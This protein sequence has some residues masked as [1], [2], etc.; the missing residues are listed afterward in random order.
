MKYIYSLFFLVPFFSFNAFGQSVELNTSQIN[1]GTLTYG[2][3]DSVLVEITNLLNEEVFLE[4]PEFFDFYGSSPFYV[5]TYPESIEANGAGSFYVVFNPIHNMV[6]NSEMVVKTSGNR[7]AVALDLIGECVYPG[8]YY[9]TTYNL[10]DEDLESALHTLLAQNYQDYGYSGARDRI[11]MEIDNQKVNGQGA[12]QN[13]LTR[14]YIGTDAVGYTSRSNAQQEYN[15]NT[16][17]TFP[18]GYFNSNFPMKS[19]MH[20]LFVSDINA[21]SVRG[22]LRFGNVVSGI[23]WSEGGSKRGLQAD[24]QTVFEP[25]DEQKGPSA[26][27]ILYFV[28]RY[29]N[30]DGFLNVT[31][32]ATLRD[33]SATFPPD[34]I[35]KT[36]NEDIFAYQHNRNPFVDYPQFLD[37]IYNIRLNEFRPEAGALA[38]SSQS[39]DFQEVE[40]STTTTYN[41][42]FTNYGNRYIA[43][44]NLGFTDNSTMSFGLDQGLPATLAIYPGESVSIP[45]TC[46]T[47]SSSDDLEA[48]LYFNSNVMGSAEVTIPVSASFTTGIE[49]VNAYANFQLAPNPASEY[50]RLSKLDEPVMF[51]KVFDIAGRLCASFSGNNTRINTSELNPGMYHVLVGLENGKMLKRKLV[52]Q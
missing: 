31:Q 23:D 7:G 21:N 33:W 27:A 2:T 34:A 6:H 15:L 32:E 18:Q 26:R 8:S 35:Q 50:V 1:F 17:H 44:T 9:A 48:N 3:P 24:G 37:R 16:E 52:K 46:Y 5:N 25:R 38:R 11:F 12:S 51:I 41:L 49:T 36:R 19:D 28:I 10:L 30:Y 39:V 20:H 13:T 29:Q 14:I 45:I 40:A 43:I 4:A 42:V 22:N 47:T